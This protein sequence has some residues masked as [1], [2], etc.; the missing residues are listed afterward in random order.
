MKRQTILVV[1]AS[2]TVGTELARILKSEGH[3]VRGTTSRTP[4][5]GKVFLNVA[6]GEG[7]SRAFA[8]VD[9]AFFLSPPGFANQYAILSPLIQEAKRR[10]L[11]KV[12]LMTAMGANANEASPL[13]QAEME[14]EK[15]GLAYNII[16]PNWFMQNFNTF[17]IQGIRDAGKI[18]LPAGNAKTSF[19]D[20]RDISE[21]AATLLTSDEMN[22]R[23]FDLT[24]PEALDHNEAAAFIS[25]ATGKTVVYEEIAPEAFKKGLVGAGLPHDYADF[26]VMIIGFLREGY[27]AGLTESVAEILGRKPRSFVNYAQ[28]FKAAL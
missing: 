21:V 22:N 7:L 8:G 12:V 18:F 13:R 16:R 4:V 9:R 6:T 27:S 26:M 3:I 5:E 23:D 19:I 2:G 20:A 17:W 11:K 24:G 10:G 25:K 28:D 15:S 14:L 1:G